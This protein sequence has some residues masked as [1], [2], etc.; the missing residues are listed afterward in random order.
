[1]NEK[2]QNIGKK[3]NPHRITKDP[4]QYKRKFRRRFYPLSVTHSDDSGTKKVSTGVTMNR[5]FQKKRSEDQSTAVKSKEG[6]R[7]QE[8]KIK[9]TTD[10]LHDV[11][12]LITGIAIGSLP[13]VS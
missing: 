3:K 5:K 2:L 12:N 10:P 13:Y 11:I 9:D 7:K 6:E 1:M 8:T 4:V